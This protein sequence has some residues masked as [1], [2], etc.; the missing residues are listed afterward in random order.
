MPVR[1]YLILTLLGVFGMLLS[2]CG[3]E[4]T[5]D[6][7][8]SLF[9]GVGTYGKKI[10]TNSAEAQQW[11]DQGLVL[12]YGFNHD[13]ATRSFRE[14]AARDPEAAMPWWGIAYATGININ[15]AEMTEERW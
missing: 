1:S 4:T 15:D 6:T 8:S 5:A 3:H 9:D 10:T 12:L 7:G 11:F 13:E 14:A 2:G